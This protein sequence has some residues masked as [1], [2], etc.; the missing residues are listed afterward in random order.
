MLPLPACQES[1][2]SGRLPVAVFRR[3]GD[4]LQLLALTLQV[5]QLAKVLIECIVK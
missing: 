3:S 2:G 5:T 4:D 1:V